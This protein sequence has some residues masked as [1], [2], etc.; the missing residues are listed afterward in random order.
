MRWSLHN[1]VAVLAVV[2]VLLAGFQAV[3]AA[4]AGVT[5]TVIVPAANVRSGPGLDFA[6]AG[7]VTQNQTLQVQGRNDASTWVQVTASDTIT[8][9]IRLD[10]VS[11]TGQ[12]SDLPVV[13][14]EQGEPA[15]G[16]S[17]TTTSA[18]VVAA[19]SA[20]VRSGPGVDNAVI[21]SVG[22]S[23]TLGVIGVNAAKDWLNVQIAGG[24]TGWIYA[25]LCKSSTPAEQAPTPDAPP[26]TT[27]PPRPTECQPWQ[28]KPALGNGILLVENHMG[29][30]LTADWSAGGHG[31][32]WTLAAKQNDV[33]GRWW[34]ELPAGHYEISYTS[35]GLHGHT[36]V[37]IEAGKAYVSPLWLNARYD[38][39]VYPLE[40]PATCQ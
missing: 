39:Y 23:T 13:V 40:I 12:V 9:W 11:L 22:Q 36:S 16:V 4:A 31:P 8:G 21:N 6:V 24:A 14:T 37:D 15:P 17:A 10:L 20:N 27:A 3:P 18:C 25:S 19:V 32:S 5:A 33:P 28:R 26:V 1:V 38:D 2:T 29:A 35:P 30:I 34:Q 7:H